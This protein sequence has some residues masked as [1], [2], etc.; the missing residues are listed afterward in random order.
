M[1]LLAAAATACSATGMSIREQIRAGFGPPE[2]TLGST[3]TIPEQRRAWEAGVADRPLPPGTVITMPEGV[4]ALLVTPQAV[5]DEAL[6]IHVHGGGFVTGSAKTHLPLAAHLAAASRTRVL[7]VNYRLAPEHVFPAARDDLLAAWRW[8]L[9]NGHD[10]RRVVISG[11]SAGGHVLL[12]ALLR[13]RDEKA[14]LPA[15]VVLISPWLDLAQRG[16]SLRTRA[17]ADPLILEQDLRDCAGLYLGDRDA[18]APEVNPLDADLGGLPPVL[19]HVGE[20]EIL[21]ADSQRLAERIDAAGGNSRL[22]VWPDLW[23]VFHSWA[24]E[25]PE[26]NAAIDDI[27]RFV[28]RLSPRP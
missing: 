18:L 22:R 25:L 2:T 6:L 11:D 9:G 3:L 20:E 26:A 13:L 17:T 10:P 16:D 8:V 14:P 24:P 27:A 23:H 7:L 19:I 21:L 4:D 15:A 12:T 28:T 1:V 5:R